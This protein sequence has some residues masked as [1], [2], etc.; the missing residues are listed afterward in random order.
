[1]LGLG[2][3]ELIIIGLV[4]L[5]IIGPE[6]LPGFARSIAKFIN[7]IKR[8]TS[9]LKSSLDEEKDIFKGTL[10]QLQEP[11]REAKKQ[12]TVEEKKQKL[13]E[14]IFEE[15]D[16]IELSKSLSNK[17]DASNTDQEIKPKTES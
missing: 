11:F 5:V 6:Q 8:T 13:E 9:D 4:A 15:E 2:F 1:M 7:E 10:D 3:W 14:G 16:L 12:I 17:E